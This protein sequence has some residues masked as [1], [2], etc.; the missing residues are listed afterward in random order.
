MAVAMTGFSSLSEG[1]GGLAQLILDWILPPS[2][3]E[4]IVLLSKVFY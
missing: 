2:R 3:K 1:Q 4:L